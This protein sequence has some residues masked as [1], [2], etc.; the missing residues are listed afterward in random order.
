MHDFETSQNSSY[1][2][3]TATKEKSGTKTTY[4]YCNRSGFYSQKGKGN[5]RL[6]TQGSCKIDGHCTSTVILTERTK[7]DDAQDLEFQADVCKTHYGHD[8]QLGHIRIAKEDRILIA[9]KRQ[10]GIEKK[11]S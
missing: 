6:K 9:N 3:S 1:C 7:I 8:R 2:K 11:E 10:A 4:F 5:R